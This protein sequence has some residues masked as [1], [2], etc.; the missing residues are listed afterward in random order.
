MVVA[1]YHQ[2]YSRR[3]LDHLA[4]GSEICSCRTSDEQKRLHWRSAQIRVPRFVVVGPGCEGGVLPQFVQKARR[5][6][7]V[8]GRV[9]AKDCR[10]SLTSQALY[11]R[12]CRVSTSD[13]EATI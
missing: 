4:E 6:E 8:H 7:D 3:R 1:S 10:I 11:R 12:L 5:P 9:Q 2:C 13:L